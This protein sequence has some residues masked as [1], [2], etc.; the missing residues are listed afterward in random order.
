MSKEKPLGTKMHLLTEEE[1]ARMKDQQ[2][3]EYLPEVRNLSLLESEMHD[4]LYN[5]KLTAED[6]LALLKRAQLR[7][8]NLKK[9]TPGLARDAH[10]L[11]SAEA[12]ERE[13]HALVT[14]PTAQPQAPTQQASSSQ[15]R[16]VEI[17]YDKLTI[18]MSKKARERAV[19]ILEHMKQFPDEVKFNPET[20]KL[21]LNNKPVSKTNISKLLEYVASENPI[22]R[23]PAGLHSFAEAL[24]DI[25]VP[26][27]LIAKSSPIR[28]Q[29]PFTTPT[30]T[31]KKATVTFHT[32][33]QFGKGL[34]HKLVTFVRP[35]AKILHLY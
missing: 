13:P 28:K 8:D 27:E 18:G 10:K 29:D 5:G 7:Y 2:V 12:E 23:K 31:R 16:D 15:S 34:K 14:Q 25:N 3:R 11:V 24:R 4:L 19:G 20:K 1:M 21:L 6:R 32:S 33:P 17:N 35:N 30:A 9:E 22:G 26:D